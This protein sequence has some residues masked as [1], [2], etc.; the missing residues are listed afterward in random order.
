VPLGVTLVG[1]SALVLAAN[2]W[3]LLGG[4]P[5]GRLP[6]AAMRGGWAGFW[7][8]TVVFAFLLVVGIGLLTAAGVA[9]RRSLRP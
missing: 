5:E 6:Y 7:Q 2:A 8:T 4:G 3:W 1:V 9:G